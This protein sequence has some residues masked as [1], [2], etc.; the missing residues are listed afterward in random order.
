[1]ININQVIS[2]GIIL[3]LFWDSEA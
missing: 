2:T 1:V 3:H